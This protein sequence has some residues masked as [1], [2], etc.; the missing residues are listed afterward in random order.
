MTISWTQNL[1]IGKN[2]HRLIL[3]RCFYNC[4]HTEVIIQACPISITF[5]ELFWW[6]GKVDFGV[7]ITHLNKQDIFIKHQVLF[8]S[9]NISLDQTMNFTTINILKVLKKEKN[10]LYFHFTGSLYTQSILDEIVLKSPRV[11]TF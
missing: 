1:G 3:N 6:D 2:S 7:N 5:T 8:C 9:V 10:C 11:D 4:P